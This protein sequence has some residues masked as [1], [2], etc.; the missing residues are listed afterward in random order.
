MGNL[1]FPATTVEVTKWRTRMVGF[2]GYLK[3]HTEA[4]VRDVGIKTAC[5]QTGKSKATLGSYSSE[6][7]EYVDRF[8]PI[9]AVAALEAK[10]SYPHVTPALAKLGRIAMSYDTGCKNS[11]GEINEMLLRWANSLLYKWQNATNQ[12]QMV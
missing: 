4:L 8:M 7:G 12:L 6:C 5:E 2:A 11:K 10:S 3:K 1:V 9:D